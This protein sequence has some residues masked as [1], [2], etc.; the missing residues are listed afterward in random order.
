MIL[1]HRHTY[2]SNQINMTKCRLGV[3]HLCVWPFPNF[4]CQRMKILGHLVVRIE[5]EILIIDWNR[6]QKSVCLSIWEE[7]IIETHLVMRRAQDEHTVST[8]HHM[9]GTRQTHIQAYHKY[10]TYRIWGLEDTAWPAAIGCMRSTL[11]ERAPQLRKD[12]YKEIHLFSKNY[13]YFA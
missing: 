11:T 7:Q 1:S 8:W 9:M 2:Y 6:V 12:P 10:N 13:S 5:N 3:I 4:S